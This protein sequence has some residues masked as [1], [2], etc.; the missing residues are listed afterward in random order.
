MDDAL[1]SVLNY[2]AWY[3][4]V[5]ILPN[6]TQSMIGLGWQFNQNSVSC[7]DTTVIGTFSENHD[8]AR[9]ANATDDL[10]QQKNAIVWNMMTDGIPVVYYGAEQRMSGGND[11]YNRAA[12]WLN[13]NGYDT[14]APLY[15]HVATLNAG[16]TAVNNA[17]AA[18]NYSNWSGYWAYKA[19][20]LY[21]TDDILVFRKGY[22]ISLV[23]ALTNVGVAGAQVGPYLIGDTN[24]DEGALI[25][26]ILNCSSVV[27]GNNGQFNITLVSG[28]PQVCFLPCPEPS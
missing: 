2:P 3:S 12:L 8:V 9:F 26:E 24:W 25:I 13:G 27:A 14:N 21:N 10:S 22:D 1:D 5:T 6:S 11:P 15:Q 4:L 19:S 23:S 16:R 20:I 18:N 17:M 28:E 7:Y